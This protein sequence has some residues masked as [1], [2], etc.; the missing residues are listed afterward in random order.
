MIKEKDTKIYGNYPESYKWFDNK[1]NIKQE[2][3]NKKLFEKYLT[4]KN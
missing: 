3:N 4:R 2:N 1:N